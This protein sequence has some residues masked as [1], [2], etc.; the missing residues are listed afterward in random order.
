MVHGPDAAHRPSP[1]RPAACARYT[2]RIERLADLAEAL[3][4]EVSSGAEG[5][6]KPRYNAAAPDVGWVVSFGADRRILGP[7]SW[8]YLTG[9]KRRLVNIRSESMVFPRFRDGFASNRCAIVT[10]GF[11]VW[12]GNDLNPVW[13]HQADDGLLLLGGLLQRSRVQGARPRF[14]VLTTRARALAA[15]FHDRMPVIVALSQLDDWLT[16]PSEVALKMS[17]SSPTRG[18]VATRVSDYANNIKHDDPGC[19]APPLD[20]G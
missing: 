2:L 8:R 18:L 10:D 9:A 3:G 1:H 17:T 16:A 6:Y 12:S 11:F 19:I 14:S 20:R 15:R 4:A 7:A 5:L 13:I